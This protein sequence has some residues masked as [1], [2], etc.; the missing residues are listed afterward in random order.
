MAVKRPPVQIHADV[1]N[2]SSRNGTS[3]EAIVL[4]TT[5][6][7]DRDGLSDLQGVVAWF[8]N[9]NAQASS[10]LI[11]DAEGNTARCVPDDRKAWT[12]FRYNP[13]TLNIELIAWAS[14]PRWRWLKR[15]RQLRKT[16]KWIA[17]WSVRHGLPIQRAWPDTAPYFKRRGVTTHAALGVDGGN[18]VD[19]GEGFPFDRVLRLAREYRG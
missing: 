6:S 5:E 8:D 14:T 4:H 10:H 1:V 13:S 3:I 16:A 12:C 11:I 15:R 17:Y 9:P 7:H 19:P 18:H 2:Q